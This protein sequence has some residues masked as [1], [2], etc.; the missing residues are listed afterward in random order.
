MLELRDGN[1][2]LI[3]TNDDWQ[4]TQQ[5]EIHATGLAPTDIHESAILWVLTQ[6]NYTAILSGKNGGVGV[7]LIEAYKIQ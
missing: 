6:G 2:A 7:A 1:G 4:S 5:T 3:A